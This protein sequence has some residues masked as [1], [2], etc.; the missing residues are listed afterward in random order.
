M[1]CLNFNVTLPEDLSKVLIAKA[2]QKGVTPTHYLEML[3]S[4]VLIKNENKGFDFLSYAQIIKNEVESLAETSSTGFCF[5]LSDL[6]C[7]KNMDNTTGFNEH[8]ESAT[9]KARIGRNFNKAV[10]DGSIYGVRRAVNEY[11][12]LKLSNGSAVYEVL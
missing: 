4:S 12:S 7:F 8:T 1:I 5:T 11:G 10:A 3:V 9:I 6:P 2:L